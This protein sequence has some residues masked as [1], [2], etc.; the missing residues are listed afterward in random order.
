[1]PSDAP[2]QTLCRRGKVPRGNRDSPS[3]PT[4]VPL[5]RP[6][7]NTT[8]PRPGQHAHRHDDDC[9]HATERATQAPQA[10]SDAERVC[11]DRGARLT[12][13]RRQ[14][15]ESLYD[16]HRPLG[17]YDLAESLAART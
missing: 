2:P 3:E 13:I 5:S 9:A 16:T 7:R 17:A 1:M 15:L 8:R 4:Q 12:T 6:S 14:V 10:L 11:R